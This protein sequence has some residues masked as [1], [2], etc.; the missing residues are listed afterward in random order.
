ML[1]GILFVGLRLSSEIIA[2]KTSIVVSRDDRCREI[3]R[4]MGGVHAN[5]PIGPRRGVSRYRAC[6]DFTVSLSDWMRLV[7]L[8]RPISIVFLDAAATINDS[9]H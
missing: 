3:A 9:S 6:N 5:G 2:L 8:T 1:Y 7:L 4:P